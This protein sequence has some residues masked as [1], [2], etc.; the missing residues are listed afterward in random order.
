MGRRKK[1]YYNAIKALAALKTKGT[2]PLG[3]LGITKRCEVAPKD[4]SHGPKNTARQVI[5]PR[6][7]EVDL[8]YHP[9]VKQRRF[10]KKTPEEK[11]KRQHCRDSLRIY[12]LEKK[13]N[14]VVAYYECKYNG[15][16]SSKDLKRICLEFG[17]SKYQLKQLV[18]NAREKMSL[19]RRPGSGRKRTKFDLVNRTLRDIV[20]DYGCELSQLTFTEL[21]RQRGISVSSSTVCRILNSE[22]WIKKKPRILPVITLTHQANRLKFCEEYGTESFG[23]DDDPTLWIDIDEKNF[24]ECNRRVM[25]VPKGMEEMFKYIHQ[26]SKTVFEKVLFFGAVAKPRPKQGFDGRVLLMPVC[27]T[28]KRERNGKYGKKGEILYERE[29]MNTQV[30][31]KYCVRHLIPAIRVQLESLPEVKRVIVQM[32]RA[33][34]HGGGRA[35]ISKTLKTLN[36]AGKRKKPHITFIAQPSKSPDFNALDLGIWY[37]LSCGVSAQRTEKGRVIDRI[38]H[39]VLERWEHWDAWRRLDNIFESKKAILQIVKDVNGSNEYS[40]PRSNR[41]HAHDG[42]SF[43]PTQRMTI[44]RGESEGEGESESDRESENEDENESK[45]EEENE[46]EDE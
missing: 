25:Y 4:N 20:L 19:A 39:H 38:I 46:S 43:L 44:D 37:S 32:D 13:W 14:A 15:K 5:S 26:T 27:Q 8:Q 17:I 33:G 10:R 22:H 23:G 29:A 12:H 16:V 7:F 18:K 6:R 9:H 3:T 40:M 45:I 36:T 31:I 11:R 1:S 41:S 24:V 21:V 2:K 30:F 35:D 28:K 42:P 34:G